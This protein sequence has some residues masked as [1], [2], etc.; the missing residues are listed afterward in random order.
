MKGRPD[1][2]IRYKDIINKLRF[3]LYE[4]ENGDLNFQLFVN[5]INKSLTNC[6]YDPIKVMVSDIMTEFFGAYA[7]YVP[8]KPVSIVYVSTELMKKPRPLLGRVLVHEIF[9]H[10]LYQRPPSLLFKLAPKRFEPIILITLPFIILA[11][12][13]IPLYST[14][15]N[16]LSYIVASSSITMTLLTAILI[17]A[18]NE[19]ELMA[20]TFVVYL[21]TGEWVKNWTYY[22]DENA[23]MSLRWDEA[24]RPR[25]VIVMQ[26]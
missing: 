18:L 15:Y 11:I 21:V 8:R 13:A 7:V 22:H 23:L 6:G 9:H 12:L 19:H 2:I 4:F 26:R 16:F 24:V 1:W 5:E 25:E 3:I 20:T 17:R 10:I 14:L